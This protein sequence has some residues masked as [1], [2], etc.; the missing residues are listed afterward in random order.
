MTNINHNK[1]V[2]SQVIEVA[3]DDNVYPSSVYPTT[4]YDY[5]YESNEQSMDEDEMSGE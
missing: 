2:E 5:D 1:K 4:H 3:R